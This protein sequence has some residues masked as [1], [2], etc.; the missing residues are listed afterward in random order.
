VRAFVLVVALAFGVVAAAFYVV[1]LAPRLLTHQPRL[2]AQQPVLF[3]HHL[4]VEVAGIQCGFCHRGSS[5]GPSAGLPDVQQCMA[6]HGVIGQGNPEIEKLRQAWIRQQPI[7]WQRV[8]QLPD[9]VQFT[10]E[11]HIQ[12]GVSCATCHGEVGQMQQIQQVRPLTMNDCVECH[13]QNN[14]PTECGVCHD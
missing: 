11:A 7:D 2:A 6:C 5:T 4:H 10:H 1:F 13:K 9:H 14:A 8:H 3:D 12:A